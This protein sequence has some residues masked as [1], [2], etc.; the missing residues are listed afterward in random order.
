MTGIAWNIMHYKECAFSPSGCAEKNELRRF[1]REK[2]SLQDP[3]AM[4]MK[5]QRIAER[6][7]AIPE[8][9]DVSSIA[10]YASLPDE[11]QTYAIASHFLN[12]GKSVSF[13][14]IEEKEIVFRQVKDP[15]ED[16]RVLGPFGIREPDKD[17]C[18]V[19]PM[20]QIDLFVIPGV[21]FDIFGSRIGFGGGYYDRA[22]VQ[23]RSDA[24]V[25]ALAFEFQVVHAI[26]AEEHDYPVD[27][28][29]TDAAVYAP[30]F[31]V[32]LCHTEKETKVFA[33]K[34]FMNGFREREI[35]ALHADLGVGKTV[36]V[37]GLAKA[38]D[39]K[40]DVISPTFMYS[41]EYQSNPPLIH[42]DAYRLDNLTDANDPLWTE[43]LEH[44]GILAIEWAERLGDLLPKS[45]LHCFGEII[46]D[47]TRQ[48][49]LFTFLKEHNQLN[50]I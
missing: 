37:Q 9:D 15:E 32:H 49:T 2:R 45:A 44:R 13:P 50:E 47:Q 4:Q 3:R 16:L 48:W 43:L 23:K 38:L 8:F 10:L 5:N 7:T 35:I 20:D 19:M 30:R 29:V 28:I 21:A 18:P 34:L 42:M 24:L 14:C 26:Q 6:F 31:S 36:F 1:M 12:M 41:R 46:D 11:S 39:A 40:D 33:K 22:L 27:M 17:R 25:V